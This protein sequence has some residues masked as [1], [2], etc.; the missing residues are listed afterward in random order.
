MDFGGSGCVDGGGRG[1]G[2]R[3]RQGFGGLGPVGGW[4]QQGRGIALAPI[5]GK[6]RPV[7]LDGQKS[8]TQRWTMGP[9][10]GKVPVDLPK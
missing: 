4:I 5:A 3:Q 10:F 6:R 2:R 9:G 8:A 1:G 7:R